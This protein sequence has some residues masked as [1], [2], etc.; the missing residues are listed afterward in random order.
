[1][2]KISYTNPSVKLKVFSQD[3]DSDSDTYNRLCKY[4]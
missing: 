1:M 4:R 3:L 2:E